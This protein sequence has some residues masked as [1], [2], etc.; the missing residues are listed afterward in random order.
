MFLVSSLLQVLKFILE[1][2]LLDIP[3]A[4]PE[5]ISEIMIAC[6]R[7]DPKER[8]TFSEMRNRLI[9]MQEAQTR[10]NVLPL[11]RPPLETITIVHPTL[12]KNETDI[13][14][15]DR[16]GSYEDVMNDSDEENKDDDLDEDGYLKA[17]FL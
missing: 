11:P 13:E 7:K 14:E 12:L 9:K 16:T 5:E 3:E 2:N 6:W 15:E 8:V 1:R 4:C 10:Y 17:T